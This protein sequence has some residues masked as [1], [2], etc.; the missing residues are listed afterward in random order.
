MSLEQ[1]TSKTLS[2]HCMRCMLNKYL[3]A[4]P[5]GIPWRERADYM[6]VVLRTMEE[7]SRTMI[8][9]RRKAARLQPRA[10]LR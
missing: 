5:E 3:D 8:P 9:K 4:C 7:G 2:P 1:I 6:R 10:F